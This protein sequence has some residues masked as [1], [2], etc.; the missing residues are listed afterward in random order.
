MKRLVLL[1]IVFATPAAAQ[2]FGSTGQ[3]GYGSTPAYPSYQ[4]MP[5]YGS[6]SNPSAHMTQGY[7]RNSGTY[8]A[9]HMQ[10][11]PNATQMDN[12]GTR[13]NINPYTGTT[14]ARSPRW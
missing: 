4:S 11:S 8:V 1:A 10:T 9:P 13:G 5:T 12:Y 14:G 6:G 3:H 7:E 2:G